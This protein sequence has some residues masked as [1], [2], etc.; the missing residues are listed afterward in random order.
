[1]IANNFKM[2]S[3]NILFYVFKNKKLFLIFKNSCQTRPKYP[4][5]HTS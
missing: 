1:M 3:K 5:G 4:F 2:L